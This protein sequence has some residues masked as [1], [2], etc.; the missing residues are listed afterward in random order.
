VGVHRRASVRMTGEAGINAG[1]T[2]IKKNDAC[3]SVTVTE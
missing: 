2:I 3:T 1:R